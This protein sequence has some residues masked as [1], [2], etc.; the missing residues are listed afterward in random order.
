MNVVLCN[1]S[2]SGWACASKVG[3]NREIVAENQSNQNVLDTGVARANATLACS[4]NGYSYVGYTYYTEGTNCGEWYNGVTSNG[5][6]GFV[7]TSEHC[8]APVKI[9]DSIYCKQIPITLPAGLLN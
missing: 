4:M 9:I 5:A 2:G 1:G 7:W 6:G 8:G 3:A